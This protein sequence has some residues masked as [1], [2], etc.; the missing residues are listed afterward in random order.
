MSTGNEK[1]E[2]I[3]GAEAVSTASGTMD[4]IVEAEAESPGNEKWNTAS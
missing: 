3:V 4:T 2:N 1:W